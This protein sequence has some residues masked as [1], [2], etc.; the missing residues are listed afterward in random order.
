MP[1]E[2]APEWQSGDDPNPGG[3]PGAKWV[4]KFLKAH[5]PGYV[6]M[7]RRQVILQAAY[8]TAIDR[9]HRDHGKMA[10]L[11]LAYTAAKPPQAAM[12]VELKGGVMAVL[13]ALKGKVSDRCYAEMWEG[14]VEL[15][16]TG[17]AGPGEGEAEPTPTS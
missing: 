6:G 11:L 7:E 5:A 14:L 13:E 1:P 17:V 15:G 12:Q 16:S 10:D 8:E 3:L 2:G 9:K 4:R